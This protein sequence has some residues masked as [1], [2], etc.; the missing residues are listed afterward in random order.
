MGK[1]NQLSAKVQIR[2]RACLICLRRRGRLVLS[3]DLTPHL[4]STSRSAFR[5]RSRKLVLAFDVG[6]TYSGISYRYVNVTSQT[7]HYFLIYT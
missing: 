4:M 3:Q 7:E 5:G 6:T 1:T 2:Q